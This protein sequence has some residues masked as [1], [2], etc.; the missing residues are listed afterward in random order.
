[1]KDIISDQQRDIELLEAQLHSNQV[2]ADVGCQTHH[3]SPVLFDASCQTDIAPCDAIATGHASPGKDFSSQG[4][5]PTQC[6]Q[7]PSCDAIAT[8]HASPPKDFNSQGM[9]SQIQCGHS[10][11]ADQASP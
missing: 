7:W 8:G 3:A 1:M 6:G 11:M 2:S 5:S 10:A 9:A 4:S